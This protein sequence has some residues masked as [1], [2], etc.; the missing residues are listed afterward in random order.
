MMIPTDK[1]KIFSCNRTVSLL[2]MPGLWHIGTAVLLILF[3][4]FS[5]TPYYTFTFPP[6]IRNKN[7][8]NI[9]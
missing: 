5:F 2:L 8:S 4:Y 1:M 9:K 3:L 6:S 7:D